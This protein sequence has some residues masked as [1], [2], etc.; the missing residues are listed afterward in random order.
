MFEIDEKLQAYFEAENK[1]VDM[2]SKNHSQS[3]TNMILALGEYHKK[4]NICSQLSLNLNGWSSI[5]DIC[6]F[7]K[8]ASD[9]VN[10][11]IEVT[12]P[13]ILV[14]EILSPTQG[15]KELTDKFKNYF[16]NG[17]HSCWLIMPRIKSVLVAESNGKE[18]I[19]TS[20]IIKDAL[21]NI[22]VEL[23]EIFE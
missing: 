7:P 4:Y 1:S 18:Q 23:G 2:P 12:I 10:D 19:F 15:M 11:E 9:W 13:P 20:G 6:L 21:L 16:K 14:I 3:W 22:E 17:V 5:P 8:S